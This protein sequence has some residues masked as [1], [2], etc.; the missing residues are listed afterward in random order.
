MADQSVSEPV[1]AKS[2]TH[3][4][5]PLRVLV[6]LIQ[7]EISAGYKA[8]LEHYRRA[9][10]MLIEAKSQLPHG[11][12]LPWLKAHFRLSHETARTYMRL[13]REYENPRDLEFQPPVPRGPEKSMRSAAAQTM[14][15]N[16]DASIR[17]GR[18][19]SARLGS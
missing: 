16:V 9:G 2:D 3:V 14:R 12:W 10:K 8:G 18:A 19:A 17:S 5:R 6:P 11:E 13:A 15:I 1:T 4:A 7:D